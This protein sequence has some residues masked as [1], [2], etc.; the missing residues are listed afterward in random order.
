[1][2][3]KIRH[4]L[5]VLISRYYSAEN[6]HNLQLATRN[7]QPATH[8][9]SLIK[10]KFLTKKRYA[11]STLS[12]SIFVMIIVS[13][14]LSSIIVYSYFNRVK[15]SHYEIQNNL[16]TNI[17]SGIALAL[18]DSTLINYGEEKTFSLYEGYFDTISIIKEV[19][20]FYDKIVCSAKQKRFSKG[21]IVLADAYYIDD[22][23]PALFL[24]NHNKPLCLCGQTLLSGNCLLPISGLKNGYVEGR[25]FERKKLLEGNTGFSGNRL[26]EN[27]AKFL[28]N[29]FSYVKEHYLQSDRIKNFQLNVSQCDTLTN[30]FF[31]KGIFI[32]EKESITLNSQCLKGNIILMTEKDLYIYNNAK[33]ENILCYAKNIFI[34][35]GFEGTVQCIAQDTLICGNNCKFNYPSNL[36]VTSQDSIRYKRPRLI[37][38][39]GSTI[40]GALVAN[41]KW[42]D[43][44]QKAEIIVEPMS[45]IHGQLY[46]NGSI[47]LKG[48]VYG[49]VFTDEF[50]LYKP[51][52]KYINHLL[53]I[54]INSGKLSKEFVG[55]NFTH[56][57]RPLKIATKLY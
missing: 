50:V 28:R 54:E 53:D 5:L 33:I 6:A 11:G 21:V 32:Y 17:N 1:M 56:N 3:K 2:R 18:T 42:K 51:S 10:S 41:T 12:Y 44:N 48:N 15:R 14:I 34:E 8:N 52:A 30:S 25:H 19:W 20:G 40:K 55:P 16:L 37:F 13:L 46:S 24:T 47:E 38:G 27:K 23:I 43:K 9:S 35:E 31:E 57:T 26:P 39:S 4:R 45:E 36:V 7:P 29:D 49:T 22:Y